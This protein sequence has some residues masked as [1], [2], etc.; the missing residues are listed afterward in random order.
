MKSIIV[1]Y[2]G[3]CPDG[4]GGAWTAYQKFGDQAD[5]IG[6]E[7]DSDMTIPEIIN[8][9]VYLIDFSLPERVMKN[10]VQNNQ[11]VIALDH[12]ISAEQRTKS[13]HEFIYDLDRSGAIITWNY[14]FP[15]KPAPLLLQHV[16]DIDLWRFQMPFTK[17]IMT[18]IQL[19]G[20]DFQKWNQIAEDLEN[21]IIREQYYKDGALLLRYERTII[22]KL[23]RR[24]VVVEFE[25]IRALATNAPIL[26][27]EVGHELSKKLPPIAIAWSEKNNTRTFS[28]R[29]DGSVDV[30]QIAQKYGGG[31]HK[32]AAGFEMKSSEPFP[33]KLLSTSL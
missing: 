5:Y 32:A 17:E 9:T 1:L 24:A 25:G 19:F 18:Y 6:L 29:S 33:W 3:R 16:Q 10:L 22:D 27:S 8:S 30:S 31:G 11:K 15:E 2:H 14:F 12:H 26:H 4:F 23:V 28:L 7:Y 13:A 20:F 21:P